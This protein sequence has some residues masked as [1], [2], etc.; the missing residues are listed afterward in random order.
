MGRRRGL[1]TRLTLVFALLAGSLLLAVGIVLTVVSY[2]AQTE[3]V[4][5]SQQKTAGEA[6][7][8]ASGHLSQA[9]NTLRVYGDVG[10]ISGLL[11]KSLQAQQAELDNL[12]TQYPE[13]FQSVTLVDVAGDELSKS[14]IF[15]DYTAQELGSQAD[16]PAYKEAVLGFQYIADEV[17]VPESSSQPAIEIGVPVRGRTSPGALIADVSIVRLWD[18]V[19]DVEV[20]ETGYVYIVDNDS[21]RL[22]AHSDLNQTMESSGRSLAHVPIVGQLTAGETDI[23]H[24]YTGL[25]GEPVIG[26]AAQLPGTNWT[27]IAELPT[28]EAM[29]DVRQMLY[30][31]VVLLVIGVVVA[32]VLGLVFPRS[33][34]RPLLALQKGAQEIGAGH[35]GYVI[36]VQTGDEIQDVAESFNEMAADLRTS[37]AELERW[38]HELE[39]RVDDRTHELAEAS[40]EMR[41]RAIQI[42][43]SAEVARAIASVRDLDQLLSQVTHL[44]SERFGWYHV[45]IFL[46]EAQGE[47]A[48]LEAANSEGGRRMLAR[49]HRLRVGEQGIVG[50]GNQ[51]R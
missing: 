31:L 45:G 1:A 22:I 25:G 48:V 27:L 4:L 6:A 38:G 13:F 30:L 23:Q 51:K 26:A 29:D 20:G 16:N 18:A 19:A 2:S 3:Q 14:S 10:S 49:G 42:Q 44:I 11:M 9:L 33:I 17:Q 32:V 34:V 50:C 41:R 39:D 8:V 21:G 46:V 47:Y 28:A 36:D 15:R 37:R 43:T 40:D 12:L 7:L 5:V 24:Q 35:L